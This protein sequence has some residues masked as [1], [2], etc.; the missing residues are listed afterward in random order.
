MGDHEFKALIPELAAWN[1]GEGIEPRAWIECI[2]NYELAAGYSLIFWP[3]FIRLEGYV[4]REGFAEI[5]LRGFE[6]AGHRTQAIEAV[7]NHIHI[8]DIHCNVPDPN[9]AQLRYLGRTLREIHE[10]KLRSDFP[11]LRFEVVFN[12]E[13][14]LDLIDYELTFFQQE[15]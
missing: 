9:E 13:P 10:V 6:R 7:M 11:D 12:D 4:L 15:S 2:G 8:S 5:S 3:R 14:G 1:N